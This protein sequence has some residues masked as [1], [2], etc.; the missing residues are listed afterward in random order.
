VPL[1]FPHAV[2]GLALRPKKQA[3][4]SKLAE[5]LHKLV[6]E[7]PGL[8]VEHDQTTHESSFAAWARC[9]SPRSLKRC[10][11]S[12]ASTWKPTRRPSPTRK[13][14]PRPAEGHHR[15]KKQTGG[16]G[17]F[18][19]VFLRIEPLPRGAGFEFVDAGQGRRHPRPIHPRGRERRAPGHERW[20]RCRLPGAGRPGD[21]LRRQVARCRRQG[22]A[23]VTAGKK[24]FLDAVA[25][26]KPVVLEPIVKLELSHYEQ[27][28]PDVQRKLAEAYKPVEEDQ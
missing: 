5:V 8:H 15:H 14:S 12:S 17:Q 28:P 13:P 22:I 7:D 19:E 1:D 20:R 16:A 23:F 9:T 10:A 3:D 11:N 6:A 26:A 4:A 24:A 2:Y 25:K 27:V 18:G 21:R